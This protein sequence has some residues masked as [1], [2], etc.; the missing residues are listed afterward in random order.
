MEGPQDALQ[1]N[2]FGYKRV[3]SSYG[4]EVFCL[5][6]LKYTDFNTFCLR[7]RMQRREVELGLL[8]PTHLPKSYSYLKI[9]VY[10]LFS[11][12]CW[13][14]LAS[15]LVPFKRRLS[16]LV[17]YTAST[18]EIVPIT[19]IL[20][21]GSGF[22]H[23]RSGFPKPARVWVC[24]GSNIINYYLLSG[25]IH[26]GKHFAPQCLRGQMLSR[27]QSANSFHTRR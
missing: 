5:L 18:P 16:T 13:F 17:H 6:P 3:R 20:H 1:A 9:H 14:Q 19:R 11:L 27:L 23:S 4:T 2:Q 21:L 26:K 24:R 10:A 8:L 15:F 7:Y 25:L 12:L 22:W